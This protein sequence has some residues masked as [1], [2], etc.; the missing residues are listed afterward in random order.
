MHPPSNPGTSPQPVPTVVLTRTPAQEDPSTP[1][2]RYERLRPFLDPVQFISV[3]I[4]HGNDQ[5][6][7]LAFTEL[8]ERIDSRQGAVWVQ[9]PS[10][11]TDLVGSE[12][13]RIQAACAPIPGMRITFYAVKTRRVDPKWALDDHRVNS[14]N[15][16]LSLINA[17]GD[18]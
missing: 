14:P 13:K 10:L 8:T 6:A 16:D 7:R 11:L 1:A 12:V 15:I 2:D 3:G 17:A 18:R 9:D 4:V 5:D